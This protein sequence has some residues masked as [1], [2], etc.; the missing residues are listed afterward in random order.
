MQL[1]P[2][3]HYNEWEARDSTVLLL[4][5]YLADLIIIV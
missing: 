3:K 1:A 4:C 2:G 5:V